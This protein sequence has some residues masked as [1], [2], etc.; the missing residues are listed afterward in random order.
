MIV[1]FAEPGLKL[2]TI[3]FQRGEAEIGLRREMVMNAG[4]ANAE[5]VG[6]ILIADRAETPRLDQL[7]RDFD[8]A[9]GGVADSCDGF[10]GH[11]ISKLF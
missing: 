1:D 9:L 3:R 7:H 4:L 2:S 6:Q 5:A 11:E 8:Q 10:G